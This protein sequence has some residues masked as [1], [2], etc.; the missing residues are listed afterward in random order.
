[1]TALPL[2][3]LLA[4]SASAAIAPLCPA[5]TSTRK[6]NE[7]IK[8]DACAPAGAVSAADEDGWTTCVGGAPDKA[9]CPEGTGTVNIHRDSIKAWFCLPCPGETLSV[10]YSMNGM[11][12]RECVPTRCAAGQVPLRKAGPMHDFQCVAPLGQA[13]DVAA[14]LP[15]D[16]G[17][18]KGPVPDC[19]GRTGLT[20]DWSTHRF[21]CESCREGETI[22]SRLSWPVCGLGKPGRMVSWKY[23]CGEKKVALNDGRCVPCPKGS[24]LSHEFLVPVCVPVAA[25]S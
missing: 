23:P 21:L 20:L 25:K 24:V 3:V 12:W 19:S 11:V 5:G 7:G 22:V 16:S 18:W 14:A 17:T 2:L 1:M 13:P 15:A 6:T 8:C 9:W 10:P 4:V